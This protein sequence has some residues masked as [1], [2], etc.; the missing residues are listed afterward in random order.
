MEL[1]H[2]NNG[3]E[4]FVESIWRINRVIDNRIV[5]KIIPDGSSEI[6]LNVG[7]PYELS[8]NGADFNLF[9]GVQLF[10]IRDRIKY[11]RQG[12][13]SKAIGI[14]FKPYSLYLLS[15]IPLSDYAVKVSSLHKVLPG[16]DTEL[17]PIKGLFDQPE[18]LKIVEQ[19]LVNHFKTRTTERNPIAEMI[20]EEIERKKGV[21]SVAYLTEKFKI[22]Y[23]YCER[24]FARYYGSTP[25]K[26]IRFRR[27]NYVLNEINK[28]REKPDFMSMVEQF[29]FHDQA[30]F[31]REFIDLTG[32]SPFS[33]YQ[34]NNTLQKFYQ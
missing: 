17:T 11:L 26:Y 18:V 3:L 31:I 16:L 25:K 7:D 4:L 14:R 8:F 9:S 22:N 23:K 2:P 12:T 21:T 33:L 30:H 24:I 32:V 1:Y 19:I 27:L 5:T 6:I 29:A 34:E 20:Y 28:I 15:G 10:F 13:N